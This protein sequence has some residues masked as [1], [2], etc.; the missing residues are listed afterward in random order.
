MKLDAKL[1]E[2]RDDA[3]CM[4]VMAI[5]M[6]TDDWNDEAKV[7]GIHTRSGYPRDGSGIVMMV[8]A[9]QRAQVDPYGWSDHHTLGLA[10][11]YI[12]EN[13]DSLKDGDVLDVRVL[14]KERTVPVES[15]RFYRWDATGVE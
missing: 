15:D 14:R 7:W 4:P 10:H 11:H 9:D 13:F 5:R 2:V 6:K 12:Y 3:T 8:L 1:V